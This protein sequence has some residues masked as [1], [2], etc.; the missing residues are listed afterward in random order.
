MTIRNDRTIHTKF[1][2][3]VALLH[4]SSVI[5]FVLDDGTELE[6]MATEKSQAF[7][8]SDKGNDVPT[9]APAMTVF[10]RRIAYLPITVDPEYAPL[11]KK[12]I[13]HLEK[14]PPNSGGEI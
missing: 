2:N 12:P 9:E 11:I 1:R 3:S 7:K 10:L 4:P 13:R 8:T 5:R 6:L 14:P